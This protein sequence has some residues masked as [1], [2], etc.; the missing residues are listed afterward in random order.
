VIVWVVILVRHTNSGTLDVTATVAYTE[1][2][3]ALT[4]AKEI[5]DGPGD[6]WAFVGPVKVEMQ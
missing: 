5:N 2:E 1:R 4:A 6:D 3:R